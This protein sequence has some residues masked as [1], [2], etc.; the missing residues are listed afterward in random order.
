MPAL[1]RNFLVENIKSE[2]PNK[3]PHKTPLLISINQL[4]KRINP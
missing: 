3:A 1:V 2:G 4:V